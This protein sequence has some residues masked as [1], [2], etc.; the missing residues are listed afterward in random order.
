MTDQITERM[1]EMELAALDSVSRSL[2][3]LTAQCRVLGDPAYLRRF[4]PSQLATVYGLLADKVIRLIEVMQ[5]G[6]MN[7]E[8]IH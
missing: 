4:S 1:T 2:S 7:Q 6:K 3:A 5:E 8:D